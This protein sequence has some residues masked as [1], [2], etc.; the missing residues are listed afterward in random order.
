MRVHSALKKLLVALGLSVATGSVMANTIDFA[1][2]APN[3]VNIFHSVNGNPTLARDYFVKVPDG[4]FHEVYELKKCPKGASSCAGK[5]ITKQSFWQPIARGWGSV[6]PAV[7]NKNTNANQY[8]ATHPMFTELAMGPSYQNQCAAFAK[9]LGRTSATSSW[10]RGNSVQAASQGQ[11]YNSLIARDRGKLVV[12]F[13]GNS[14]YPVGP[15]HVGMLL[16]YVMDSSG[17]AKGFWIVDQNLQYDG[18]IRKHLLLF[19]NASGLSPSDGSDYHFL[20]R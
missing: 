7:F 8:I 19:K 2:A 14:Q 4:G 12:Y 13:A 10:Y 3:V 5:E 20:K 11:S 6:T 9:L 1:Q 15:G 17:R 16:D 18:K